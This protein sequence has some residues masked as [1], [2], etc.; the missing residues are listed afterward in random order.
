ML[1]DVAGPGVVC[2]DDRADS[3][4]GACGVGSGCSVEWI[5]SNPATNATRI[6]IG[7]RCLSAPDAAVVTKVLE[8][9]RRP[10]RTLM[11]FFRLS[12]T[13]GARRGE[14]CGL[15]WADV[16]LVNGRVR[17]VR[18]LIDA[19]G[20]PVLRERKTKN[21]N[22]VDLDVETVELLR[23]HRQQ[24]AERAA[25]RGVSVQGCPLFSTSDVTV[26]RFG[27]R[28]GS[29]HRYSRAVGRDP[30]HRKA[31]LKSAVWLRAGVDPC[32]SGIE[33]ARFRAGGL[34]FDGEDRS[35]EGV[36]AELLW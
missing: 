36:V 27:I 15:S 17:L 33:S 21:A 30:K 18:G 9:L 6:D 5:W 4:G 29:R 2:G 7:P 16:D 10:D 14:I 11:M 3:R 22:S 12:A 34:G 31:T 25:A 13:T 8:S 26:N 23:I 20:G 1:A 35:R 32:L 24:C 28:G 19:A